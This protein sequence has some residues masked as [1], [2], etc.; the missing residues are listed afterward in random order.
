M[1]L[2]LFKR[3]TGAQPRH[4]SA[5]RHTAE[6]LPPSIAGLQSAVMASVDSLLAAGLDDWRAHRKDEARQKFMEASL[7]APASVLPHFYL[8]NCAVESG[9]FDAA[10]EH[11][12]RA[13]TIDPADSR[14]YSNLGLAHLRRAD[15]ESAI[16][17]LR[18]AVELDPGYRE[19]CQSLLYALH[20]S[21]ALTPEEITEA[22]RAWGRAFCNQMTDHPRPLQT[23]REPA[24]PLRIGYMSGDFRQHSVAT[25]FESIPMHHDRTAFQVVCY[26]TAA[27]GDAVTGRLKAVA[28]KWRDIGDLQ[29][30]EAVR[31]IQADG[32]DLLVDLSGHTVGNRLGVFARRAAPVQLTYL[33][34]PDT[35]GV[36]AMDF[37]IT[38]AITD[39]PGVADVLHTERLLR[40]PGAQWCYFPDPALP[41]C[42]PLPAQQRGHVTFGSFNDFSKASDTMLHAWGEILHRLPEARLR[43]LRMTGGL[44]VQRAQAILA[45]HGVAAERQEW[46]MGASARPSHAE[47]FAGVDIALD[48][49][50]INGVTTTVECLWMGIPLVSMH[51]G[52]CISR[53]GLSLLHSV[54]LPEL[55]VGTVDDYVSVAVALATDR[56]HLTEIR[57]GLRVRVREALSDA[58]RFVASLEDLYRDAWRL[59]NAAIAG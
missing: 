37:R 56:S 26:H 47:R 32:I 25:F 51:G 15:A 12:H 48:T 34:Y 40:L 38:D 43:L 30:E 18:K 41:E 11:Y 3:L 54:G 7:L 22:H 1:L 6:Q 23:H 36:P 53:S 46:I 44:R 55:A 19:A 39:P 49:F 29:D 59:Q 50:P 21:T 28:D 27:H 33:G 57:A 45:E 10:V 42:G 9:Q 2:Q 31:L 13:L 4:S 24:R 17:A 14:I 52:N 35:T 20:Y 5:A 58:P 8:G 16:A